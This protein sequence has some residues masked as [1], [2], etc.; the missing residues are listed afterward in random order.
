MDNADQIKGIERG[1]STSK[2]VDNAAQ[3]SWS[4]DHK[5][6][7]DPKSVISQQY[8]KKPLDPSSLK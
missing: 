3:T 4:A 2:G 7:P 5:G 8:N 1:T 6:N